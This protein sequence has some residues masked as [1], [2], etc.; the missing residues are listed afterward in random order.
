VTLISTS[1]SGSSAISSLSWDLAGNG[2][3]SQPGAAV[4]TTFLTPGPHLVQLRVTNA[5]GHSSIAGHEVLVAPRRLVLMQPFPIVRIAGRETASGVVLSLVQVTAPVNAT[6]SVDCRGRGCPTR[7]ETRVAR[8]GRHGSA[9]GSVTVVFRRFAH[10]LRA[11]AVLQIRVTAAGE[12][13]KYTRFAIRLHR[14]PARTDACVGPADP[15]PI[16]CPS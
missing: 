6:V 9:T 5:E 3:F 8:A 10:P 14:L 4:T 7:R 15:K 1:S 11:G 12:I 2:R 16:R 13:G